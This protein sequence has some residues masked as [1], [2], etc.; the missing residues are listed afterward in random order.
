MLKQ[1]IKNL[2]LQESLIPCQQG[3]DKENYSAYADMV[4]YCAYIGKY[5]MIV[6]TD[7]FSITKNAYGHVKYL[8]VGWTIHKDFFKS[9]PKTDLG[10]LEDWN[11][12]K[13]HFLE[14]FITD[15][16]MRNAHDR[17]IKVYLED[18][19]I[20]KDGINDED[21]YYVNALVKESLNWHP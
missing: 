20:G 11:G 13:L 10:N 4:R 2:S 21:Y 3:F 15:K 9:V 1:I 7:D 8:Q 19:S 18:N 14:A 17:H 12:E 16:V 5:I 6:E